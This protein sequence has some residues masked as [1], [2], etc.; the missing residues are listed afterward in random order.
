[1]LFWKSQYVGL[2]TVNGLWK[3]FEI[4]ICFIVNI[5]QSSVQFSYKLHLLKTHDF[6]FVTALCYQAVLLLSTKTIQIFFVNWN[7]A[8]NKTT[9]IVKTKTKQK[10]KWNL[11]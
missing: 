1:M 7:K 11:Q 6:Q 3:H 5:F 4:V 8:A 9:K 2:F 10:K